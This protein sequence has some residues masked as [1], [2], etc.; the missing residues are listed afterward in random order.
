[1]AAG[2]E[3]IQHAIVQRDGYLV[4]LIGIPADAVL[5]ECADCHDVFPLD[6]ITMDA[7][8]NPQCPKC[9]EKL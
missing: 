1:M 4:P 6:K 5:E 7:F 3:V 8:G 9:K 2:R